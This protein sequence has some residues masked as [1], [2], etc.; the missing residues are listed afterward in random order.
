MGWG[1]GGVGKKTCSFF[2]TLQISNFYHPDNE[3]TAWVADGVT[4]GS[5]VDI[6]NLLQATEENVALAS[7]QAVTSSFSN[8]RGRKHI[9]H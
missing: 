8:G 7:Q 4:V 3:R 2:I 5:Q 6:N 1:G 9:L